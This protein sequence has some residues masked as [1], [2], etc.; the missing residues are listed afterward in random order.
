MLVAVSLVVRDGWAQS[1][2]DA[3]A[4]MHEVRAMSDFGKRI[5]KI[6]EQIVDLI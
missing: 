5:R 4:E 1:D 3:P 6:E 2:S